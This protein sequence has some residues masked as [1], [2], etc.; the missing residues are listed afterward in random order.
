MK[1]G[2]WATHDYERESVLNIPRFCGWPTL[3]WLVKAAEM[4]QYRTDER[5]YLRRRDQALA[6]TLF[7]TGGRLRE[8]L[9]LQK[10]NFKILSDKILVTGM[11]LLKRFDKKRSWIERRKELPGNCTDKL[12]QWDE[13]RKVWWRKRWE[14]EPRKVQRKDFTISLVEPLSHILIDWISRADDYLFPASRVSKQPFLADSRAYTI[15]REIE[16]LFNNLVEKGT[17]DLE[18]I[19]LYN[20]WF[21][22]QRASQLVKDYGYREFRLKRFFGWIDSTMPFHYA[23]LGIEELEESWTETEGM[24]AART[25]L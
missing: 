23:H 2:Y 13:K 24:K 10:H 8:V 5:D 7:Q 12:Y 20:H 25:L 18:T 22:A 4:T 1:P 11:P 17:I 9:M 6:T 16:D 19:R 21:R 14:T 3:V 15:V